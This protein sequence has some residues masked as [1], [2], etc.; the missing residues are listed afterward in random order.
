M[1]HISEVWMGEIMPEVTGHLSFKIQYLRILIAVDPARSSAWVLEDPV[2]NGIEAVKAL[3]Q[4][5]KWTVDT[6]KTIP[7]AGW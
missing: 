1:K 7:M 6:S 3:V 5:A 2:I 4:Q